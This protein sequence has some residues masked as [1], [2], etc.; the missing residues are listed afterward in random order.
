MAEVPI[1]WSYNFQNDS[2]NNGGCVN[3]Y[4]IDRGIKT[5]KFLEE[6]LKRGE[7]YNVCVYG[8]MH[9]LR[10]VGMY[11]GIGTNGK[12][13]PGVQIETYWGLEWQ[14]YYN[15]TNVAFASTDEERVLRRSF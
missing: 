7:E 8:N 15:V 14:M 4:A 5:L 1:D 13:V 12:M 2:W 11:K 9:P 6:G 3:P 10:T